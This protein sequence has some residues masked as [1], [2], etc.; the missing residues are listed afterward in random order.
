VS[1]EHVVEHDASGDA[2]QRASGAADDCVSSL[3]GSD[4]APAPG[5]GPEPHDA[6][7]TPGKKA[8]P[9]RA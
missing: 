4:P 1:A 6:E 5:A 2:A 7:G 3:T 8:R 9:A